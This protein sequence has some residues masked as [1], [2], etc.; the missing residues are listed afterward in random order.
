V[1]AYGYRYGEVP[2]DPIGEIKEKTRFSKIKHV[3]PL[4][5]SPVQVST[6]VHVANAALP[7]PDMNDPITT[8]AGVSKRFACRP[9]RPK[10][11]LVERLRSF[12]KKWLRN[13]LQPLDKDV[14]TSFETWL[15]ATPY[16]DWRKVEL[17]NKWNAWC[18][19][20]DPKMYDVKSFVKDEVYGKYKHARGINSRTDEFK[21]LVGPL[22]KLIEE[23]VY[24]DPHFIKHIPVKDR[25]AYIMNRLYREDGVYYGTDY[26]SFEALFTAEL[27]DAVEFELYDYMTFNL[28]EHDEFMA[29]CTKVLAGVNT[30]KFKHFTVSLPATRMS[31]E[32][33]TSL[34]NGFSNLMFM[35]F[36]CSEMGVVV[37]GVVDGD[38]GLFVIIGRAPT[39]EDF[40][41]LGLNLKMEQFTHLSRASF[42]GI[43]FDEQEKFNVRDPR[44]VLASFGWTSRQFA[45]AKTVRLREMLR[46]KALSFAYQYP[47]CPIIGSLAQFGLRV[48]SGSE[49][50]RVLHKQIVG[51]TEWY[52]TML[53]Q[54]LVSD[55]TPVA[56][57]P[58]T[59]MLVEELYGIPVHI[60]VSIEQYLDSKDELTPLDHPF[61]IDLMDPSWVHYY[62][63]YCIG[64]SIPKDSLH[65]PAVAWHKMKDW[66][67][68]F[69]TT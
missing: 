29:L 64:G 56:P 44:P 24:K 47:G 59:R 34:G 57:G 18:E 53:S 46:C 37:D 39:V 65:C 9:P 10:P 51:V 1:I 2:L 66:V 22:F 21:C 43:V 69:D 58:N 19:K 8:K 49:A 17:R 41:E 35:L 27:M 40:K 16:A 55:L 48:T 62:Q 15:S 32:M 3:D 61:I 50:R 7:H 5:R 13:N 20:K 68:E 23:Q 36:M 67:P 45:Q 26:T 14:D 60:Q 25:P 52:R 38:D 30:C 31:G 42:C 63:N 33:C 11:A 12:T 6:G 4:R 28:K 54:A